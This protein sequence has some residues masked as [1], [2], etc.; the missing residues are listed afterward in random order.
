LSTEEYQLI[1]EE[2]VAPY[3]DDFDLYLFLTGNGS[4][5]VLGSTQVSAVVVV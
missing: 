4:D 1:Q 5:A 3:Q 2:M